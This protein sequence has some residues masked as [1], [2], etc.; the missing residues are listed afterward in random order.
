LEESTKEITWIQWNKQEKDGENYMKKFMIYT[1]HQ[2]SEA[3]ECSVVSR[4]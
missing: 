2:M 3:G 1:S 4:P